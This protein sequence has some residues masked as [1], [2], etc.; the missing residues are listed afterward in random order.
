[1]KRYITFFLLLCMPL[2][3]GCQRDNPPQEAGTQKIEGS[4]AYAENIDVELTPYQD[5]NFPIKASCHF[6]AMDTPMQLTVYGK[7]EA[8]LKKSLQ[9]GVGEVYRLDD[10]LST[11]KQTSDIAHLNQQ[12]KANISPDT[13]YLLARSKSL[14]KNTHG[15]FNI[16]IF[17]VVRAWGFTTDH[18]QIP[19]SNDLE[20]LLS[21]TN[22]EDIL[23][24]SSHLQA[25]L[26]PNMAVDLGAIAKG[27]ASQQV[28]EV[29]K[30]HDVHSGL[31]SLGGN[32]QL[33]GTKP[34]GEDFTVA[35]Q[36]PFNPSEYAGIVHTSDCAII[37]SGSYQ[38]Y[39]EENGKRYHHIIDPRTGYPA[40]SGL[41]S[42]S[43]ISKDSS[44]A[45]AYATALFIMGKDE[46][47]RFW[48]T[49]ENPFE[50]IL[51]TTSG[52]VYLTEG[53]ENR[54]D[55]SALTSKHI[56]RRN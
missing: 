43:I 45:D 29:L 55:P 9:A 5:Q 41:V 13:D 39:F 20:S 18:F 48:K 3:V 40:E 8:K 23:L 44:L 11:Q 51:L 47:I 36:N 1:M 28:C 10:L 54:Y 56:I 7:D 4:Y 46:A 15:L 30:A 53:L 22:S 35:I 42:V 2:T 6:S 14:S 17:P 32:V 33:I 38:R 12:G 50:A 19:N 49:S 37:T 25:E 24:D 21:L 31:V 52:D 26:K 34:G 27:Y 16:A